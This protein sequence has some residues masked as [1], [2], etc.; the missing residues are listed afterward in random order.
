LYFT[1]RDKL[2]LSRNSLDNACNYLGIDGKT[3]L[4]KDIW[5]LAK[6]GDRDAISLVLTH[7]E[8]DVIIT[9]RLHNRI[10]F[11]RKWIKTSI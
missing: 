4:D 1:V 9:E 10:E 8:Y 7:C 6:Y 5:R 2:K 11:M 3:P